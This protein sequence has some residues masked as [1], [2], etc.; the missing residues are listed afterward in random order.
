MSVVCDRPLGHMVALHAWEGPYGLHM[1]DQLMLLPLLSRE[2]EQRT[3]AKY[4]LLFKMKTG[5]WISV[6]KMLH[7]DLFSQDICRDSGKL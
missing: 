3:Y 1:I 4:M 7:C 2:K 5:G 6:G